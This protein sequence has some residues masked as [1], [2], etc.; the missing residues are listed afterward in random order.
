MS[1]YPSN[2]INYNPELSLQLAKLVDILY[3]PNPNKI[4]PR[5]IE[6][7]GS[8]FEFGTL[9][10][11]SD[12]DG[13]YFNT[14]DASYILL[15]GSVSIEDVFTNINAV[16]VPFS[17]SK[18]GEDI[19]V[20]SGFKELSDDL[21]K[22]FN[23]FIGKMK[24]TVY[25]SG[26]SLGGATSVILAASLH[27][28]HNVKISDIYT[29]ASPRSGNSEFKEYVRSILTNLFAL[30]NT[31]DYVPCL[32]PRYSGYSHPLAKYLLSEK[33]ELIQYE[34]TCRDEENIDL[35]VQIVT[36]PFRKQHQ[37]T[38]Y[39]TR[40]SHKVKPQIYD[41]NNKMHKDILKKVCPNISIWKRCPLTRWLFT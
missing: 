6:M 1:F 30:I 35:L 41:P 11:P 2:L 17:S 15:K 31:E 7:M 22:Q 10:D 32:P 20:H 5:I 33:G 26:H 25:L 21:L 16:L 18:L 14:N 9:G 40:L 19:K 3:D 36:G 4:T 13:V 8:I 28:D 38:E 37:L 34:G 39:I 27:L 23:P 29:F 24:E 12:L